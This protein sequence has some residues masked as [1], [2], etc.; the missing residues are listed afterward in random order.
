MEWD[1]Y[2]FKYII[3]D[4]IFI[5]PRSFL[6]ILDLQV[7]VFSDVLPPTISTKYP[8]TAYIHFL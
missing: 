5:V 3:S 7:P 1:R 2:M 6:P 4:V 8:L